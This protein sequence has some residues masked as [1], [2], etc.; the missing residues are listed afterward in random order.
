MLQNVPYYAL[1]MLHCGPLCSIKTWPTDCFI[2]IYDCSIRVSRSF[3]LSGRAQQRF[4][5]PNPAFGYATEKRDTVLEDFTKFRDLH[6]YNMPIMPALCSKLAYYASIMLDAL[7]CLLCR[8]NRRRPTIDSY[9]LLKTKNI[10][11]NIAN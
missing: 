5:G 11:K 1:I 7:A 10:Y 4:R 8:H 2:R 6:L 9:T 3:N